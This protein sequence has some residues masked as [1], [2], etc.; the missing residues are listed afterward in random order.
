[1][2]DE[3]RAFM[4]ILGAAL[5]GKPLQ[6][7]PSYTPS[8][9]Q[10]LAAKAAAHHV[11]PLFYEAAYK[12]PQGDALTK[13]APMVRQQ[14]MTQ[15]VRTQQLEALYRQLE[16]ENLRPLIVKGYVC[17]KLYPLE[18]HRPS[19]DEDLFIGGDDFLRCCHALEDLGYETA[20]PEDRFERTYRCSASGLCLELHRHL[21]DPDSQT[22]GSWNRFFE[23][24]AAH[25]TVCHGLPTLHPTEHML[26]LLLHA[27]KHFLHSGFGVRQ[28]CDIVLFAA[29]YRDSIQWDVIENT[30]VQLR[31]DRFAAALFALGEKYWCLPAPF[32]R[33]TDPEPLLADLMAAG[34]YGGSS[35]VRKR[36]SNITLSAAAGRKSGHS[37]SALFPPKNILVGRFPYLKKHPWL[38][39]WAW[40]C[41]ILTYKNNRDSAATL[42][43]GKQRLALLKLYGIIEA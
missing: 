18:D 26:Y 32:Y 30:L 6:D 25:A 8:F 34:V 9:L 36:S 5:T 13:A 21:F 1:M 4:Q 43:L 29:H 37:L 23:D 2:L 42:Q 38:L 31:A 41:R 20:D 27:F 7:D 10:Q 14:V 39:P 40:L 35:D 16:K 28:V 22:Y 15:A 11:L 19:S 24:A 17:R 12:L 33:D 3:S